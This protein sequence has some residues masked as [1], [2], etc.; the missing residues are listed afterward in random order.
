MIAALDSSYQLPDDAGLRQAKASGVGLWAGYLA[1]RSGTNLAAPWPRSNFD[2][3]KAAGLATLAFVSGW[4]D[5]VAV[6]TLAAAWGVRT[7]LDVEE[8]IRGDGPWV[9]PFLDASG[10][11]LYGAASVFTGRAAPF[12]ILAG[13]YGY[14][15]MATWRGPAPSVP[16][17]WQWLGTHTEFGVSV[18]RSWLD[19]WFA[20]PAQGGLLMALTDVQQQQV[21]D[22]VKELQQAFFSNVPAGNFSLAQTYLDMLG[23]LRAQVAAMPPGSGG[24]DPNTQKTLD[25]VDELLKHFTTI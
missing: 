21:Y 12:G 19:N 22:W 9:Q 20:A 5:P 13:Y 11:G 14:D 24:V 3:I 25:A 16:H 15:P 23:A 1:T 7:G 10:S 2:R 4:D 8:R 17:G 6:R 18:D